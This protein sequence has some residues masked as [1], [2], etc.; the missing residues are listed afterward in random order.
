LYKTYLNKNDIH[1]FFVCCPEKNLNVVIQR[2][3]QFD[4]PFVFLKDE[5]F[6]I[7]INSNGTSNDGWINQ[8]IIKLA[9]SYYINTEHY[10]ILDDDMF[11]TKHLQFSDFFDNNGNIY[12]S[13]E[14]WSDNGQ[15]YANNTLWLTNSCNI[16]NYDVNELKNNKY[17]F[18]VTPQLIITRIVHQLLETIGKNWKQ[19]FKENKATE[20]SLYW[21]YLLKTFRTMYYTPSNIF[22]DMDHSSHILVKNISEQDINLIINNAFLSKKYYFLVIQSWLKYPYN[23]ISTSIKNS[24]L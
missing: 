4:L 5:D 20:F 3:S 17:I 18:G 16:L 21:I 14:S 7:N 15:N 1:Q 13:F 6:N 12:Y 2:L 24:I 9:I 8:Q 22:F 19:I 11:L 10:L 23:L